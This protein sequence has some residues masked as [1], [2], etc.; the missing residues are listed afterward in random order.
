[1]K[2]VGVDLV[3]HAAF[4]DMP[5]DKAVDIVKEMPRHSA[6]SFAGELTYPGYKHIPSSYIFCEKDALVLPDSQRKFIE[7]ISEATGKEVDVHTLSSGHAPNI[8]ATEELAQVLVEVAR[9]A[10]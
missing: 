1:M 7:R 8:S 5:F 6:L 2:I 9:A 4:S 10:V 3:A